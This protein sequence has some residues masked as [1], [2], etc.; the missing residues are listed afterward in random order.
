M[1]FSQPTQ[2]M[3]PLHGGNVYFPLDSDDIDNDA[4][5][6]SL[7]HELAVVMAM[8]AVTALVAIVAGFMVLGYSWGHLAALFA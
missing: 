2:R 4:E 6:A 3:Q 7:R 8:F 5:S 1:S